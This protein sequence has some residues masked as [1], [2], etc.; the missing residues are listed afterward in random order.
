MVVDIGAGDGEMFSNSRLL[1]V[2]AQFN[3][4][5]FEPSED[6]KVWA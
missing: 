1:I 5:L 6:I 4:V 3:G 2:K